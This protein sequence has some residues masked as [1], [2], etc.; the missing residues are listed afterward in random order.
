MAPTQADLRWRA[1]LGR[2]TETGEHDAR[3]ASPTR[4]QSPFVSFCSLKNL[5]YGTVLEAAFEGSLATPVEFNV[6]TAKW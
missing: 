2:P 6:A 5:L 3:H 4:E 1:R